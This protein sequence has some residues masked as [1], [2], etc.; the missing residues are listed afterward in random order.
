MSKHTDLNYDPSIFALMRDVQRELVMQPDFR[1]I[2]G[3]G[4]ENTPPH[5][6]HSQVNIGIGDTTVNFRQIEPIRPIEPPPPLGP[7]GMEFI[8]FPTPPDPAA[9][10]GG[11]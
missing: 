10:W 8:P 1:G 6:L 7:G 3:H 2:G 9:P 5:G 4:L 11:M